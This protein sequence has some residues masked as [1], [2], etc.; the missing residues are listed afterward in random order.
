M[1]CYQGLRYLESISHTCP[2]APMNISIIQLVS[3]LVEQAILSI[4]RSETL[5]T[6]FLVLLFI[7]LLISFDLVSGF[8][9]SIVRVTCE[10]LAGI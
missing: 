8:L 10:G 2:W 1:I 3:L 4:A 5:K 7:Y 9:L 6:D